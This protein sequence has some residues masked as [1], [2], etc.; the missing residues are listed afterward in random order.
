[1]KY[2][3][4]YGE[5]CSG[6]NYLENLMN[7]NF[8][9]EYNHSNGNK[10]FFGHIDNFTH[11]E[12]TL[13]IC[14]VRT[15]TDWINSLYRELYHLPL[16]YIT[17]LS[18]HQKIDK[19]LNQQIFSVNDFQ[20]NYKTWTK[21]IHNDRNIYTG[22]RYN[23]IF[24]LRHTKL[25]YMIEDLPKKVHNYIF[26]K[27]DDLLDDFDN[28]MFKLKV[29]GC[30]VKSEVLFPLNITYY[31]ANPNRRF[32]KNNYKK[33]ISHKMIVNNPNLIKTY[34]EQLGYMV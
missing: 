34:E 28:V 25:K 12:D 17:G 21:E 5:R 19:F 15:L 27:Y 20:H 3:T 24:E 13:F 11:S 2:Y 31:K 18:D 16:K 26:I 9:I 14:I 10:H 33:L 32:I 8:N 23:N 29:K 22:N 7:L 6:T 1:M 4:I 30:I